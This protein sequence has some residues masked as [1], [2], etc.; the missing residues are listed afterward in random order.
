MEALSSEE[1]AHSAPPEWVTEGGGLGVYTH[2]SRARRA[3]AISTSY[4]GGA[5]RKGQKR[6]DRDFTNGNDQKY[7]LV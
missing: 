5:C 7:K 1:S 6:I 2:H 3:M 4:R